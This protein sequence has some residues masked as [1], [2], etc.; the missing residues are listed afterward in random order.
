MTGERGSW[1]SKLPPKEQR[2]GR[3]PWAPTSAGLWQ[4]GTPGGIWETHGKQLLLYGGES[5]D[6]DDHGRQHFP[7]C[8]TQNLQLWGKGSVVQ[9]ISQGASWCSPKGGLSQYHR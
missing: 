5:V 9:I 4:M 6:T 1:G 3:E 8:V 2:E 7:Q